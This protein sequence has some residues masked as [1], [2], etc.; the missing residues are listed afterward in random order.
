MR[1]PDCGLDQPDGHRFCEDC[2]ARLG[3]ASPQASCQQCA[4][5][6]SEDGFCAECGIE[7]PPANIHVEIAVSP[8]LAGVSD[9]GPRSSRNEDAFA[10]ATTV[11]GDIVVVCDGVSCSQMPDVASQAAAAC[12]RT[13]LLA[14]LTVGVADARTTMT[15]A[16]MAAHEAVAAISHQKN[17]DTH[18][19]E[20]TVV[21]VLRQDRCVT[22]GWLGDSRAYYVTPVTARALTTDH[23]WLQEEVAAGRLTHDEA[24]RSRHAHAITRTLGGPD[25]PDPPEVR[26]FGRGAGLNVPGSSA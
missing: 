3:A 14:A 13:S 11:A 23:S 20:T 2:G 12:V 6:I 10:V 17:S 8:T 16:L 26:A 9:R 21:A 5:A 25:T 4:G 15:A 1:C 7:S 19:P 18:P 22:V 24:M